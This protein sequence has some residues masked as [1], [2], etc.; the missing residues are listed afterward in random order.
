MVIRHTADLAPQRVA[1]LDISAVDLELVSPADLHCVWGLVRDGLLKSASYAQGQ[2]IPEDA[3]H[4][5]KS[6]Q[7]SLY[8]WMADGKVAGH[9]ILQKKPA[10]Y[11]NCLHIWTL[12]VEPEYGPLI[13]DN[14][15]QIDELGKRLQCSRITFWSPRKAWDRRAERLGFHP[16]MTI[17]E[18]DLI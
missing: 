6:N 13:D 4:S 15:R 16:A 5:I 11:G 9:I 7:A 18:K 10:N 12:Y 17:Y 3:Y 8:L 2:W 14:M 1:C